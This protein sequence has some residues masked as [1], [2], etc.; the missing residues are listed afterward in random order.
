[1][2]ELP[3]D[4]PRPAVQ[5]YRGAHR[6]IALS[7]ESTEKLKEL[8]QREG[9][10]L[11]MTLLAAFQVL[12]MRYTSQ[13]DIV[14]GSPIAGRTRAETEN[15]IGFF[16]N[17]LVLRADL[18]GDPTFRELLGRVREVTFGAYEHQDVPFEKLVE[19]LQPER[20][21]SRNPL[22]QVMF[23]LLNTPQR[24]LELSGLTMR[25]LTADSGT[26]QFD[27]ALTIIEGEK[28]LWGS[29]GYSMDL[30]DAATV[31]RM[32]GHFQTL[33]EGIAADP[34]Q[35]LSALPI[36][37]EAERQQ[38]L[39]EWNDTQADYPRGQCIHELFEAQVEHLSL[40]HI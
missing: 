21:L 19:E 20:S 15:L 8:S 40:I 6:S 7:R 1:M 30:F 39:M 13:E 18:S 34:D 16:I 37:T 36:L 4:R 38:L 22:F 27:V 33:L 24:N 2:L 11:F 25:P 17:T 29:L 5:S 28:G 23:S 35:R 14:V 9:A 32:V 12:L 26:T 3:T 31:T 10:T